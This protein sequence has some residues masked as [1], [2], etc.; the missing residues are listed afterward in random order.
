MVVAQ[1]LVRDIDDDIVASLKEQ[2]ISL[3]EVV[4]VFRLKEGAAIA[5]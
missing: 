1:L 2:A 4:A 5:A 3:A